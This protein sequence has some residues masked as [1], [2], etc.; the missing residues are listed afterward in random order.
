MLNLGWLSPE[1]KL[2][3]CDFMEHISL[4]D[5]LADKYEDYKPT[6]FRADDFL[7]EHNWIHITMTMFLGHGYSILYYEHPKPE[8]IRYLSPLLEEYLEFIDFFNNLVI[9]VY[10]DFNYTYEDYLKERD[11]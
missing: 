1:G 11:K 10:F 4:A 2:Y 7:M 6:H 9:A 5:Q 8:Q 3:V